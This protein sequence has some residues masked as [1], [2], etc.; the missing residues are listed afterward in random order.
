MRQIG[1]PDVTQFGV[2]FSREEWFAMKDAI[3][4]PPAPPVGGGGGLTV[5]QAEE[6]A[7][8]GAQRAERE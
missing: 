1:V 7:F 5:A 2:E 8:Q 4:N 3:L 6:A